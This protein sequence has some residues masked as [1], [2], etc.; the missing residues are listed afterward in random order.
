[1]FDQSQGYSK[2]DFLDIGDI[3]GARSKRLFIGNTKN[4]MDKYSAVDN[5]HPKEMTNVRKRGMYDNMDYRDVTSVKKN[6]M[7]SQESKRQQMKM[8]YQIQ[9]NS[10]TLSHDNSD[11]YINDYNRILV[12]TSH[13]KKEP[14]TRVRNSINYDS[15]AN[16]AARNIQK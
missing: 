5:S 6:G 9:N 7:D 16:E 2:K 8:N 12:E 15:S 14:L 10:Q 13:Q 4:V 1:M 11:S 3:E